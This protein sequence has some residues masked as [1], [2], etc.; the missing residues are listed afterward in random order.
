MGV[1]WS[2]AA[3]RNFDN[4]IEILDLRSLSPCDDEAI[5]A[6]VKKHGKILVLT[7]ETLNNSFAEAIAGRI[8]R[9]CFEWLDAP[10]RSMG[11]AN[12]PAVPLNMGLEKVMLPNAQKVTEALEALLAY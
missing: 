2:E 5:Y 1:W 7:E 4:N 9:E 3:A 10:V 11:S 8:A 6:Q 12:V